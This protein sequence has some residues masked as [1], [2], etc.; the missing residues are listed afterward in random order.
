M[1]APYASTYLWTS[2][3][4]LKGFALRKLIFISFFLFVCWNFLMMGLALIAL[5][6]QGW[7]LKEFRRSN[8]N[9]P[10]LQ[11]T[12]TTYLRRQIDAQ[13]VWS[14]ENVSTFYWL[15][16]DRAENDLCIRL[17]WFCGSL[18]T[19]EQPKG[20]WM[21]FAAT[22]YEYINLISISGATISSSGVHGNFLTSMQI[23]F[24]IGVRFNFIEI[25]WVVEF[26]SGKF[27]KI[28]EERV[29]KVA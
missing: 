6:S 21:W 22:R 13:S 18:Q 2:Q 9:V 27:E 3:F 5:K 1:C 26:F 4:I 7:H 29:S 15:T 19:L 16:K 28:R 8:S 10:G 25:L 23:I 24:T 12:Q 17:S 11:F 14:N 20:I